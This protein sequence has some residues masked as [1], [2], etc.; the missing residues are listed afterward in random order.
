MTLVTE[1]YQATEHF[2]S[3]EMYGLTNQVRRAAVGVPSD[4]AEGK[5][6]LSK[7][8]FVQMLSRARGSVLEV[9]T[10]IEI[11][12]NLGFLANE[13]FEALL[14]KADEVG[15]VING[16]IRSIRKQLVLPKS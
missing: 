15:R 16:L 11:A 10:Q 4:I 12:R 3:R 7:K 9:Q 6:R 8:E 5:G 14:A 2:P 13:K 1:I